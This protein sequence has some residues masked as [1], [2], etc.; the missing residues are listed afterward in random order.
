MKKNNQIRVIPT[1]YKG[2]RFRSRLEARWAVFFDKAGIEWDYEPEGY[3]LGELGWYLPDFYL[4]N[5]HMRSDES[6]GIWIEIKPV[7]PSDFEVEKLEKL[8]DGLEAKGAL[9]IGAPTGEVDAKGEHA[10]HME[11]SHDCHDICMDFFKCGSCGSVKID[12]LDSHNFHCKSCDE[13]SSTHHDD[14][15]MA[16]EASKQADFKR[17]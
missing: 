15:L 12:F 10:Y 5:V 13:K 1:V 14:L 11:I 16:Y 2:Y 7:T 3:D 9:L 17:R 6:P 8:V 4:K